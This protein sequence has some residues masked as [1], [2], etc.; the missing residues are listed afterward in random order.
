M[1]TRAEQKKQTRRAILDA[2]LALLS[3][4]RSLDSLGLR[5]VTRGAG[6][7]APSFYRHFKD[8]EELGL[9]LV[10]E[11]GFFLREMLKKTRERIGQSDSAIE[12]SVDTFI[13]FLQQYPVH[14]RILLQEQVGYSAEFRHAVKTEVDHFETELKNYLD[15]RSA[16]L[17]RP[18]LDSENI[19]EA[20]VAIVIAMGT[21]LT[22]SEK[23]EQEVW[24]QKCITQLTMVMRGALP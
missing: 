10:E 22:L 6:L 13:E 23:D 11:A 18:R 21:K 9:A 19:A 16:E 5:E 3:E 14:F 17:G 15:S 1:A 8:M 2:T 7:A 20:M 24:R 4:Q 12:T